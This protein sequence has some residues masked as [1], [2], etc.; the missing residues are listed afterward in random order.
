MNKIK[1]LSIGNK[2]I[3]LAEKANWEKLMERYAPNLYEYSYA[4][5][6]KEAIKQVTELK[7]EII[8]VSNDMKDTLG[9]VEKIKEINPA[10]T[11]F[12]VLGM[13]DDEQEAIDAF[14]E[15]GVYKSYPAPLS[16][17]TLTH[18]MYVALN[19]E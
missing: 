3:K 5:G 17:D 12:V 10:G 1:L 16:L 14:R 9:L 7:P 6:D 2:K 19:L 13:V 15:K 4:I 8:I 18:D 11:I